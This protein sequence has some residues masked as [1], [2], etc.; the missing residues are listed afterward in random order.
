M[1]S[2]LGKVKPTTKARG[3]VKRGEQ[4]ALLKVEI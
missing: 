4:S 3:Q 2:E 1:L